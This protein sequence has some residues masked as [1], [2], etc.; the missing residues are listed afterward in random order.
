MSYGNTASEI[1]VTVTTPSFAV[2]RPRESAGLPRVLESY[3][4]PVIELCVVDQLARGLRI[5]SRSAR[6]GMHV[7][8][9][10]NDLP[11]DAAGAARIATGH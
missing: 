5:R 8:W 2:K 10:D 11:T 7:V 1:G 3:D 6:L 9:R 4:A